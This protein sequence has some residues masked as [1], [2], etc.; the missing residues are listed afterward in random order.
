MIPDYTIK[1]GDVGRTISGTFR[2]STGAIVPLV[3]S[4][5][6]KLFMK[7]AMTGEMRINGEN[8]TLAGD[9]STGAWSYQ[10]QVEDFNENGGL[11]LLEHKVELPTQ[12]ISFP[13][14]PDTPHKVVLV[15]DDLG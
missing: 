14:N 15:Q 8:F 7:D 12:T 11:Y 5:S 2:D 6:R 9:G 4:V 10:F 3:G 1:K 13:T